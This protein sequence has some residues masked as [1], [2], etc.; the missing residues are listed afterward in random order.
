MLP[1]DT[2]IEKCKTGTTSQG[3]ANVLHAECYVA[4]SKL[5]EEKETIVNWARQMHTELTIAKELA[6]H[7]MARYEDK[8]GTAMQEIE[9]I[10]K[11]RS[12]DVVN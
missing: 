12:S 6:A 4:I 7:L 5:L 11:T 2:L 3:S 10:I 1:L 9:L 8:K